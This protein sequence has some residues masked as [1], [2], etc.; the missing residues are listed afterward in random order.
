MDHEANVRVPV[1]K[2]FV[3]DLPEAEVRPHRDYGLSVWSL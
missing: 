3:A 2:G 1:R